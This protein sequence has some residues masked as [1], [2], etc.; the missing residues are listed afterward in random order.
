MTG[1]WRDCGPAIW[2]TMLGIAVM[3][4]VSPFYIGALFFGAAIG[5]AIRIPSAAGGPRLR[6]ASGSGETGATIRISTP[7]MRLK[8]AASGWLGASKRSPACRQQHQVEA[9]APSE[10]LERL[11]RAVEQQH[12]RCALGCLAEPLPRLVEVLRDRVRDGLVVLDRRVP[13]ARPGRRP[14]RDARRP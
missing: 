5:A 14:R 4:L 3:L 12:E 11:I 13:A 7:A 2:L 10:L 8:R 6:A 9:A 1:D